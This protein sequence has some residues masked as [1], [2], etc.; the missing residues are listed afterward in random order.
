[1]E[2]GAK[3]IENERR[4]QMEKEG[5]TADHDDEHVNGEM[6]AAAVCY[7]SPESIYVKREHE[8]F[9]GFVD[10]WP[11]DKNWDKRHDYPNTDQKIEMLVKAGALIAAEIDR[12]LRQKDKE[13]NG[14]K[15]VFFNPRKIE[16][17]GYE[18]D[19]DIDF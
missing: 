16:E 19:G 12:L 11:W 9:V 8:R 4:R 10:P 17:V 3:L 7:A 2:S 1:M 13:E 15:L 6:A 18:D 14:A 5:W